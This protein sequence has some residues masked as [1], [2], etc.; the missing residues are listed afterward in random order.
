M[1]LLQS[2][3]EF[4]PQLSSHRFNFSLNRKFTSDAL[5][6]VILSSGLSLNSKTKLAYFDL[7]VQMINQTIKSSNQVRV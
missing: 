1:K 4:I 2:K 5:P 3:W 6:N 7:S